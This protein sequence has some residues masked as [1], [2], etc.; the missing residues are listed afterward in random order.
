MLTDFKRIDWSDFNEIEVDIDALENCNMYEI[1]E[2][3]EIPHGKMMCIIH[4]LCSMLKAKG[5]IHYMSAPLPKY[6]IDSV[7]I[8]LDSVDN[9]EY[10]DGCSHSRLREIIEGLI[11]MSPTP[12]Q[13]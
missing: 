1:D 13:E 10:L 2:I 9:F 4:C 11:D 12:S 6:D 8:T 3:G 5:I 7:G